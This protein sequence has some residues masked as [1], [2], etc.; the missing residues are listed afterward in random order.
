MESFQGIENFWKQNKDRDAGPDPLS[1]ESLEKTIRS[2][3]RGEKKTIAEYFWASFV[4]QILIYAFMGHLFVKNW[5]NT[6]LMVLSL[7]GVALYIPFTFVLMKKFKSMY[8]SNTGKQNVMNMNMYN[9]VLHQYKLLSEFFSFKKKFGWVG[10]P[11]SCLLIV[12]IIFKLYTAGGVIENVIP[13]VILF[14]IWLG[15]FATAI[16][17]ENKKR[18]KDPLG[19]LESILRDMKQ[20]MGDQS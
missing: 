15:M 12:L 1:K 11:L 8:A 5:G 19:Q 3:I 16:Y 4:Y 20:N 13:A 10:V 9:H 18:F 7:A 2:R 17:Y 6:E 14:I